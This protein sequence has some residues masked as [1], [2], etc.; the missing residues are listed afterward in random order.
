MAPT[1]EGG[2]DGRR[3]QQ[4]LNRE[5]T[6]ASSVAALPEDPAW[7]LGGPPEHAWVDLQDGE[8]QEVGSFLARLKR[9]VWFPILSKGIGVTFVLLVLS[10]IGSWSTLRAKGVLGLGSPEESSGAVLASQLGVDWMPSTPPAPPASALLPAKRDQSP[11][12][13]PETQKAIAHPHPQPG[14]K[15]AGITPDGKVI[16]NTASAED[17]QRLPGVGKRRAETI[18]KLREK[19]KRFR[20]KTDLLRVRGIGVRTLKRL[21]PLI[22]VDPP[23]PAE[24]AADDEGKK[25]KKPKHRAKP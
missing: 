2:E 13:G 8:E 15:S 1:S 19:L 23:K 16:L 3:P 24:E 9:S 4:E 11:R 18:V 12:R 21:S 22:V 7:V 25:A 5:E 17:F 20:R 10:L 6:N 14:N